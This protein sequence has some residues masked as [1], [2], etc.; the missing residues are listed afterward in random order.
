[1]ECVDETGTIKPCE[2]FRSNNGVSAEGL[3][4]EGCAPA[5]AGVSKSHKCVYGCLQHD[6]GDE[7]KE[8]EDECEH[9]GDEDELRPEAGVSFKVCDRRLERA[10]LVAKL[11]EVD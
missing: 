5:S 3:V 8:D 6:V 2:D 11:D 9:E 10:L 4:W 7:D 1:M